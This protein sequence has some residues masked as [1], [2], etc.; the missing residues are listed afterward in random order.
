MTESAIIQRVR[1]HDVERDGYC[2]VGK[3]LLLG[4]LGSCNGSSE[5]AHFGKWR[6]CFTRGMEPER[7]HLTTGSMMLCTK[8]HFDYDMHRF[9]VEAL[10]PQ[11]CEGALAFIKG[12]K[13]FE[14][15]K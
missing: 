4:F 10:T 14:E 9:D 8:H 5:W 2:R 15:P 1:A 3:N 12:D 13:R 7:R 11:E 6:R